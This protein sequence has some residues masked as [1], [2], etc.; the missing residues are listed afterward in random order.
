MDALTGQWVLYFQK[1]LE[2]L[3][4]KLDIIIMQLSGA[5]DSQELTQITAKVN[6]MKTKLEYAVDAATPIPPVP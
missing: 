4:Q 3:E 1:R 6:A 5:N 2:L